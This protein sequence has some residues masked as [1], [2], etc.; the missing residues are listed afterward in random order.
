[1]GQ[2]KVLTIGE[3]LVEI[4]ATERGDG[5]REPIKLV[6]PYP[7]GAPAIFIDQV[8]KLGQASAIISRVGEDDFGHVNLERLKRDGVDISGIEVD[9]LG[10]TGSAFVRYREDGG[11]NFVFNI[12]H[13]ACGTI[14]LTGHS[15]FSFHVF[16][17][18]FHFSFGGNNSSR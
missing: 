11:R 12:C 16:Q 7:S 3:V 14:A 5:F 2:S 15:Q 17:T 8:G 13:S 10:T 1:M 18:L 9:P 6:G 4:V